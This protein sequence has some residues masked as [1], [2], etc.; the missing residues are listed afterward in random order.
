M[1]ISFQGPAVL[2]SSIKRARSF[3]EQV[4]DQEVLADHGPHVAFKGGFFIWQAEHA[5]PIMY[6]GAR[7]H[8]GP[9]GR[10]NFELYF[11]CEDVDGAFAKA[12]AAKAE[13]VHAV[14]EQ[15][16]GQKGFRVHDPDGHVVEVAE[17]L[18]A[19]VRRLMSEGMSLE[20]VHERTSIPLE[21][22]RAMGKGEA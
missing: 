20:Q 22:V 15:P 17:P 4:L 6:Q 8:E 11:E 12:K 5:V 19:L 3:Y 10:A 16:W 2:V 18:P 1:T 13:T 9:L 21:A 7:Q 14:I